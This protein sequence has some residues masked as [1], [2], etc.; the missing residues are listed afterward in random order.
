MCDQETP[1][2]GQPHGNDTS[3]NHQP[4]KRNERIESKKD[5]TN[6]QPNATNW[7]Q[8]EYKH[9]I[10][11]KSNGKLEHPEARERCVHC[12]S[13]LTLYERFFG[14]C[15]C[16]RINLCR[17]DC[18]ESSPKKDVVSPNGNR[19][20]NL[21][22]FVGLS[23]PLLDPSN[24]QENEPNQ[25]ENDDIPSPTNVLEEKEQAIESNDCDQIKSYG[26]NSEQELCNHSSADN[27]VNE[28]SEIDRKCCLN[29]NPNDDHGKDCTYKNDFCYKQKRCDLSID[30]R[31]SFHNRQKCYQCGG[32]MFCD[33]GLTDS[34]TATDTN[35]AEL[36]GD[37]EDY[38]PRE[39]EHSLSLDR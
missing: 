7:D 17:S 4:H 26:R 31:I 21:G 6:E 5:N 24:G 23:T 12:K 25:S 16:G 34:H 27:I 13:K 33:D 22:S 3:K 2:A 32:K 10:N 39:K 18:D 1:I 8:D 20:K 38:N 28:H 9:K 30:N 14:E 35:K 36:T 29:G 15:R 11:N 37:K 19:Q